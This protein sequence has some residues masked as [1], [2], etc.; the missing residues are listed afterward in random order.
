MEEDTLDLQ[1]F[2]QLECALSWTCEMGDIKMIL[3]QENKITM[4]HVCIYC[5]VMMTP[6]L[7]QVL[8]HPQ[9]IGKSIFKLI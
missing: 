8:P 6:L 2:A 4:F 9:K 7:W 3:Q 1:R 5:H